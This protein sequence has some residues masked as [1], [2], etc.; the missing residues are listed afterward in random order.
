MVQIG[1]FQGGLRSVGLWKDKIRF[2]KGF[3]QVNLTYNRETSK[4]YVD[5]SLFLSHKVCHIAVAFSFQVQVK[6][7]PEDRLEKGSPDDY[8]CRQG[9]IGLEDLQGTTKSTRKKSQDSQ[10]REKKVFKPDTF[11]GVV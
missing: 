11:L 8:G 3:F 6:R 2:F 1:G 10:G 5:K 9:K 7:A 4:G